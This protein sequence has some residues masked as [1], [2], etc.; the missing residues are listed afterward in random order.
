MTAGKLSDDE[1]IDS[2]AQKTDTNDLDD[3]EDSNNTTSAS[4][5]SIKEARTA[6]N[7]LPTFIEQANSEEQEFSALYTL[8][9]AIDREQPNCL[10]QKKI[11]DFFFAYFC[12]LRMF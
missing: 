11:T 7:T 8:D 2:V 1:I 4:W 12:I 5:V 9:N 3:I 10:K 6:L